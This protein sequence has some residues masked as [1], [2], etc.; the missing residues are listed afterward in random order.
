MNSYL[1]IGN[2]KRSFFL[3]L[4]KGS[5]YLERYRLPQTVDKVQSICS[6]FCF[7]IKE[8]YRLKWYNENIKSKAVS[9]YDDTE[10]R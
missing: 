9:P 6:G 4:K 2:K 8:R 7:A 10:Y 1:L 5:R 3:W